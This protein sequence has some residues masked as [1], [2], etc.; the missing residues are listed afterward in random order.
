ME[1]LKKTSHLERMARDFVGDFFNGS[2]PENNDKIVVLGKNSRV[3][4]LI[5]YMEHYLEEIGMQHIEIVREG[6]GYSI[7]A[8]YYLKGD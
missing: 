3:S 7:D 8:D 6:R 4:L 5:N 1:T 2:A